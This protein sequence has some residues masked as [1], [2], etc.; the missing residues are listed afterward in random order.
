MAN[1][2]Y[3]LLLRKSANEGNEKFKRQTDYT[4]TRILINL[5]PAGKTAKGKAI[6]PFE[7]FPYVCPFISVKKTPSRVEMQKGE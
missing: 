7:P 4:K 5:S 3:E 1:Q 6:L 2:L